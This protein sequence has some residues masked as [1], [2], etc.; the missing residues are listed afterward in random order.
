M[1]LKLLLN[2]Y[3]VCVC[4]GGGMLAYVC[5]HACMHAGYN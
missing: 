4:G 5:V 3:C 2:V 1:I